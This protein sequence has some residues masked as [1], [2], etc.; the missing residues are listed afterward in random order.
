VPRRA[1]GATM[2]TTVAPPP[3][4]V[5]RV[6]GAEYP[7]RLPSLR[8]P[9]LHLAATITSIQVMGQ[10]FLAWELS[11]AQILV[12]LATCAV[13]EM[14][15]LF[16]ERREIV[17]PASALLTGNGVALVLRV[18]GTEHGD[19]WSMQGWY[20]FAATAGLA[21]LS[22]HLVRFR[23]RPVINPS[24]FGL[25]VCFLLLGTEVV[26]PLDFWWGPMSVEMLAVYA[27]LLAGALTVTRRLGLLPMSLA[28]W[29]VFAA[30]LAV[31]SATGHCISA[32][33]SVTPVCGAD[34]WWVVVTSPEVVIFMLFMITD[35]MTTPRGARPRVV[36]GA[37]VGLASALLV[38]P[39]QT[40]F[41]A[42]VA[43]LSG[44]V[45]VCMVRP[46][47]TVAAE[48]GVPVPARLSPVVLGAVV[49]VAVVALVV[50]GLP[51]REPAVGAGIEAGVLEGRPAVEVPDG[52][53]PAVTVSDDVRTVVGDDAAAQ[54]DRMAH[55]L[56]A[57]L[58]IEADAARTE[59][60]DLA[61]SAVGGPRLESFPDE[62]A[63]GGVEF[64]VME[65]VL[66]R[67]AAD[68]QAVPR[69]GIHGRG[70]SGSDPLD[71][72]FVLEDVDGTWL[73]M[74]QQEPGSA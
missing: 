25:V 38:A 50:A 4:P 1:Y 53:V 57:D 34:F 3:P 36:F 27:I 5:L 22:K 71:H 21:L 58:M 28:F 35:P 62:A 59:D 69:F 61:A 52:A 41:G 32:R 63:A 10:A 12:S 72:V 17:W 56:V 42:K 55:D 70:R 33:W 16:H 67:D 29:A 8:D 13:I 46:V 19:W 14:S 43:V 2:A 66:V 37:S 24:N 44:L 11:I 30:S 23:G 6:G 49:P 47:L 45:L 20:I 60:R 7:V 40:E 73:L 48:R 65:V 15:L 18:N 68:P 26:N 54:A 64:D 51:A 74:E 39:M 9:R 31:V